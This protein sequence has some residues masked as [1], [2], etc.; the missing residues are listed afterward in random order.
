[1]HAEPFYK[2]GLPR[3]NV[4]GRCA[5][6]VYGE[7]VRQA[8][9]LSEILY[10]DAI[11]KYGYFKTTL[12]VSMQDVISQIGCSSTEGTPVSPFWCLAALGDN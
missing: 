6:L 11:E 5:L 9:Q 10:D 12:N 7:F 2:L 8:C 1:V 4:Q 3:F